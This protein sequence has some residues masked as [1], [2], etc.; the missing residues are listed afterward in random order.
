MLSKE[1]LGINFETDRP[2]SLD[3]LSDSFSAISSLYKKQIKALP[4]NDQYIDAEFKLYV[5]KIESKCI[6]AELAG[7]I[8]S[9]LPLVTMIDYGM[10]I[11][12]FIGR[13]KW[14]CDFFGRFNGDVSTEET[15]SI[16]EGQDLG[17]LVRAA[18][19]G[20]LKFQRRLKHGDEILIETELLYTAQEVEKI[21]AGAS[22][23]VAK[24]TDTD[25][26]NHHMVSMYL[27]KL[28]SQ[29]HE[30]TARSPDR[31]VIECIT[32]K[33]L[34]VHWVSKMDSVRVKNDQK[35]PFKLIYTVDVNVQ[36]KRGLPIAYRV[37]NVHSIDEDP[38]EE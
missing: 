14:L 11:D 21:E 28:D 34:P 27:H 32:M 23:F 7:S 5:T 35:N 29:H 22:D 12:G 8:A 1:R 16:N 19:N 10:A 33:P 2:I 4:Q 37:L 30:N 24:M 6:D 18:K 17:K 13:V 38:T 31:G 20:D 25:S 3:E 36:T 9:V 15:P 26:D